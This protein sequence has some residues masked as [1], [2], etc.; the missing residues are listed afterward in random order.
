MNLRN[1]LLETICNNNSNFS[2][3]SEDID[4]ELID[5]AFS[6]RCIFLWFNQ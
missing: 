4:L 5:I 6:E 2:G 1:K 3:E